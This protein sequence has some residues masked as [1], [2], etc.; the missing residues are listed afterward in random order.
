MSKRKPILIVVM[1]FLLSCWVIPASATNNS[2]QSNQEP[3]IKIQFGKKPVNNQLKGLPDE[4]K[5]Q[6]ITE[7]D[8]FILKADPETGHF[9]VINK[10][11]QAVL[12]SF[13]NPDGW[14]QKGTSAVW[15]AHLQSPIMFSYVEMNIRKDMVKESNLF[16]Q[17][18]NVEFKKIK[19]GFQVTYTMPEIGFVIPI[20]VHLKNDYVETK[21]LS[22]KIVDV[23]ETD[24]KTE[25]PM[26]RLV[27]LRAYPFLG[28]ETSEK[29]NGFLLLPDG[30]GAL[31]DFKK[32]R[33]GI[34]SLYSERVYGED[35]AF[36]SNANISTR[37]P[38]RMPVFGIKSGKQAILGVIDKGDSYAN[39]VSAPSQSM[40]QYNW[41]TG[42]H[43]YRFKVFQ[44]TNREKTKGFFTYTKKLQRTERA[45]RYYMIAKENTD[46]SDMAERYRQ[47]LME[48]QGFKRNNTNKENVE[49]H[50]NIL[51]GGTKDGFI[52]D[53]FLSLTTTDQAKKIVK[54]L[55]SQGIKDMSI[56]YFGWQRGG[57]SNYGGSFPIA[58]DLGGN[59]GMKEFVDYAHS[60]G[61]PVYLDGSS[62][63]FN[64]TGKDGF[65]QSRDGLRDL[66]SSVIKLGKNRTFVSPR[67][68]KD[69]VLDDLEKAKELGI[70]G[71]LFGAGIGSMLTTD[72]NDRHL[73]SRQ[74][75]KQ[76]QQELFKKTKKELGNVRVTSG[77]LYALNKSNYIDQ[78]E[79]GYSFDLFVD[80]VV[81]FEQIALHG[82]IGYSFN[83]GNM[84]GDVKET[85]LK[86]IEY[87]GD[88]S[89]LVTHE[90]T[91]KLLDSRPLRAFYSTN[92]KDWKEE[93]TTQYKRF[94][95]A[96]GDVQ[97]QFI[98]DHQKIADGVFETTYEKGKRIIV[99]Y[100]KDPFTINGM[101]IGAEDFVVLEGGK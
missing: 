79:S 9:I 56:T 48:E 10:K 13:P 17:N 59:S 28:A 45:T 69:V 96:L 57:Y 39:I 27:S 44:P 88:P 101:K 46:Y 29:E 71:Y 72:F 92:F 49:L 33:P 41:I 15:K 23:K 36:S 60:K 65:R 47:Y 42:E 37:L 99:N 16:S 90:K 62:Y 21:V 75:V 11:S 86:G 3:V 25:D 74:E 38:V 24:G 64:N 30:S 68:M 98:T 18:G 89:F 55:S 43:L 31:I 73:A 22:D 63:T 100:N 53:S 14:N 61:M 94:N 8:G 80:R 12:R 34:V 26:A 78:M 66:G 7:N 58:G 1:L 4:K 91:N 97:S 6:D 84:S 76:I 19:D 77:N 85:F 2:K 40:S 52:S 87:G 67:F 20:Q 5:F 32:N 83:Y 93:I 81:P 54:N 35:I 51:G 70:D 95:D 50:L 82:L